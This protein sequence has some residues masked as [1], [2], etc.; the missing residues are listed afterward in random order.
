MNSTDRQGIISNTLQQWASNGEA[1]AMLVLS[2]PGS[3]WPRANGGSRWPLTVQCSHIKAHLQYKAWERK[4]PAAASWKQKHTLVFN[5]HQMQSRFMIFISLF[6]STCS[7]MALFRLA[8]I[9]IVQ[10]WRLKQRSGKKQNQEILQFVST[11]LIS[12]NI[13]ICQ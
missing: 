12:L 9:R 3:A 4:S 11:H 10:D 5:Y 7:G 1:A 2:S 13:I 8:T 6:F